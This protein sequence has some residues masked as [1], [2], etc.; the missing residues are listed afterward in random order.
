MGRVKLFST[1]SM[2]QLETL[3]GAL[4][5][6]HYKKGE[7]IFQQGDEGDAF[8]VV[9]SGSASVLR[10]APGGGERILHN[11]KAWD[12]FGERVAFLGKEKR[13]AGVRVNSASMSCLTVNRGGLEN[14]LGS[15]DAE[16]LL[17]P[18]EARTQKIG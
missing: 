16:E 9:Q 8:Y 6:R 18:L 4:E 5:E 13:Y 12:T 2:D 3:C 17:P 15:F 11:L 7:W 10:A 1:L 14:A